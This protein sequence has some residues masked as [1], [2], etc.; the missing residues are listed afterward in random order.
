MPMNPQAHRT[1][2]VLIAT[3]FTAA[4]QAEPL[5]AGAP[6]AA[7]ATAATE[8]VV[9]PDAPYEPPREPGVE[10][11]R[12]GVGSITP[13]KRITVQIDPAVDIWAL[14][15]PPVTEEERR[16]R[17]VERIDGLDDI[18]A[19][20]WTAV[21]PSIQDAGPARLD[22][23]V[24]AIATLGAPT[25]PRLQ[26]MR[27]ITD[28]YGR[29]ILRHTVGTRVSPALVAAIISVESAGQVEAI[30]HAG[31]Q[32]LM[33]LMPAT[34]QRFGVKNWQV[35]SENI[36]GGVAYLDWL[37][38]EFGQDPLLILAGYNAGEG[39]VHK[40]GG[41]PPYAETRAYVPKVLAAWRVASGLCATPPQFISDGCVFIGG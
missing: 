30:S 15:P 24:S 40:H 2:V 9:A 3:L 19:A 38:S 14:S 11:K 23:A 32:G 27:R 26:D 22:T 39:A 6:E 31:A 17:E 34:A 12:I 7:E 37:M 29:D 5:D 35:P 41:V 33:Q 20:F 16:S 13:G 4:A 8:T 36:R 28:L 21:S 18:Y 10:P 1:A 25:G